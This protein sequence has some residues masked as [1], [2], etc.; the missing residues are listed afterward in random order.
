MFTLNMT[1]VVL[2]EVT[3]TRRK[4]GDAIYARRLPTITNPVYSLE[5]GGGG[6]GGGGGDK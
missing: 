2:N 3:T 4:K 1:T 6:G 5:G